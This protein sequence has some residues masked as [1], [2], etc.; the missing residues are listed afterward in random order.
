M[1]A[2]LHYKDDKKNA[3]LGKAQ[4]ILLID[5]NI[6]IIE[7]L[8]EFLEM[9]GYKIIVANNGGLGVELARKYIPDLI[10]CDVLMPEMDGHKV[11]RLLSDTAQTQGIPFIFSTS[12]S[13]KTDRAESLK[14]GAD[15]YIVKPFELEVLLEII[16]KWVN[17]GSQR[18]G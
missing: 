13:E 11:L 14:L 16:K 6:D 1:N 2:Y 4:T 15:D 3:L 8:T 7:N 17:T 5:D 18:P 10:I 12:M 9:E